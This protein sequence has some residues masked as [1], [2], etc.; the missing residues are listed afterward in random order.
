MV[1]DQFHTPAILLSAN[2]PRYSMNI[3]LGGLQSQSIH[4]GEKITRSLPGINPR[5]LG[6]SI[7]SLVIVPTELY[8]KEKNSLHNSVRYA[9]LRSQCHVFFPSHRIFWLTCIVYPLS[10]SVANGLIQWWHE[11]PR[12]ILWCLPFTA[13][14]VTAL[15]TLLAK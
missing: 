8:V 7:W 1:S 5:F 12:N 14:I 9:Q 13:C 4:C 10:F 15:T 2:S 3:A 6:H 11:F